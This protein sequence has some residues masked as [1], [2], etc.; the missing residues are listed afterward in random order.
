MSV[1]V[2]VPH[3]QPA[4]SFFVVSQ[5]YWLSWTGAEVT[6][7]FGTRKWCRRFLKCYVFLN[8]GS[9]LSYPFSIRAGVR[10]GGIRSPVLFAVYV[11]VLISHL[12]CANIGCKLSNT[13]CGCLL[14]AD[15]IILLAH[16]LND[17]QQMLN[18]CADFGI[19]YCFKFNNSKSVAMW[20]GSHFNADWL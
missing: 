13:Y 7:H 12:K 4:P 2:A 18:I 6:G 19:E 10:Q 20:I 15:D 3:L 5:N 16:T 17:V 11:N 14:Y 8:W 1:P 9:L